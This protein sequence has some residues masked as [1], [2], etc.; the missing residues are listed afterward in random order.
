MS[1][2]E[3]GSKTHTL[4]PSRNGVN[5]GNK[6][7]GQKNID[8]SPRGYC[9][10]L[11]HPHVSTLS[12]QLGNQNQ[13]S[14]CNGPLTS[15]E[16]TKYQRAISSEQPIRFGFTT[17]PLFVNIAVQ[18]F[19]TLPRNE[20]LYSVAV[21]AVRNA[22]VNLCR[23]WSFKVRTENGCS[24]RSIGWRNSQSLCWISGVFLQSKSG[25]CYAS[26]VHDMLGQNISC[27]AEVKNMVKWKWK[28]RVN[29]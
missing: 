21:S 8:L 11:T 10:L 4:Y 25:T 19:I 13:L 28:I 15:R 17:A 18:N 2:V 6:K 20:V 9:W 24:L 27:V 12:T 26:P 1:T 3:F 5:F 14:L 22:L 16:A 29:K 23:K 7:E